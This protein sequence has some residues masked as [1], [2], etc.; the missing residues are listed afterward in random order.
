MILDYSNVLD[1][2]VKDL[3]GEAFEM[4]DN[5]IWDNTQIPKQEYFDFSVKKAFNVVNDN[6]EEFSYIFIY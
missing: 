1:K 5:Y 4:L 2:K 6:F 3:N